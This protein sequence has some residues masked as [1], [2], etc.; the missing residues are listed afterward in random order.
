MKIEHVEKFSRVKN[1]SN[2][3][4]LYILACLVKF[5]FPNSGSGTI[6]RN[7]SLMLDVEN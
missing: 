5:L 6:P 4:L 1:F 7:V 3:A 2:I